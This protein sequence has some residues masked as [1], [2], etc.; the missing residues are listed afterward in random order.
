MLPNKA[1]PVRVI[2]PVQGLAIVSASTSVVAPAMALIQAPATASASTSVVAP[3][4]ASA[5]ALVL[6]LVTEHARACEARVMGAGA[7]VIAS[8]TVTR[9]AAQELGL[10]RVGAPA[11]QPRC[12]SGAHKASKS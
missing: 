1:E 7:G 8:V 6:V 5:M 2:A 11:L 12:V 3:A 9:G 10:V 4:M